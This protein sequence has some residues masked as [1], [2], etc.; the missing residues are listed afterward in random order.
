MKREHSLFLRTDWQTAVDE[1]GSVLPPNE[2][3]IISG[4]KSNLL[5]VTVLKNDSAAK[6]L[7]GQV[8][9][10]GIRSMAICPKPG[11]SPFTDL[12]ISAA[13]DHAINVDGDWEDGEDADLSL[14]Q[15]SIRYSAFTDAL[16]A[17]FVSAGVSKLPAICEVDVKD[18]E[19]WF[20]LA[21]WE[22][23]LKFEV[24]TEGSDDPAEITQFVR[25]SDFDEYV[26]GVES[27]DVVDNLDSV[28]AEAALSANQG[29]VIKAI[30]GQ[31]GIGLRLYNPD[32]GKFQRVRL[33]G[34]DNAEYVEVVDDV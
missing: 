14:G 32:Q 15:V 10:F 29:S 21:Q 13:G 7:T 4:D 20:T 34:S 12:L 16:N 28:D 3:Q 1:N 33:R 2:F 22:G 19:E 30:L 17:L 6:D 9:R 26:D 8:L 25:K 11:Q 27:V 23:V 18:G 31:N 24:L 5:R